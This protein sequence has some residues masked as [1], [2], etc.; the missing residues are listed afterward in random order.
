MNNIMLAGSFCT[1]KGLQSRLEKEFDKYLPLTDFSGDFQPK[2]PKFG[3]MPD[4]LEPYKEGEHD[5]TFL[6]AAQMAKNIF[7]DMRNY[8]TKLD[9]NQY[10]PNVINVKGY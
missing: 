2:E 4:Y 1:L 10:G 9:Y 8:L 6:G 7:P 3:R 5:L